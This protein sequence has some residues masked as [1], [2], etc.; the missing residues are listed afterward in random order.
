MPLA[1]RFPAAGSQQRTSCHPTWRTPIT[2]AGC[3]P[4]PVVGIVEDRFLVIEI[5]MWRG[6]MCGSGGVEDGA[7][8]V[9]HAPGFLTGQRRERSQRHVRDADLSNIA[10]GHSQYFGSAERQ[11]AN[12]RDF[13]G[14][15]SKALDLESNR[16]GAYWVIQSMHRYLWARLGIPGTESRAT[17]P[18]EHRHRYSPNANS[19]TL[20]RGELMTQRGH[21]SR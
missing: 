1:N 10:A 7:H 3:P 11:R 17:I 5:P 9:N 8:P 6:R 16:D 20:V 18:S 13:F 21:V 2:N 19:S 15:S 4:C 12:S 14:G